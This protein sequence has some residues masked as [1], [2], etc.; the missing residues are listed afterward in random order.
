MTP[1]QKI[2]DFKEK[3][4]KRITE[5]IKEVTKEAG[6]RT[7]KFVILRTLS[8][9]GT[10]GQL[11]PLSGS[12]KEFRKRWS[13]FLD[14]ST[15]PNKSNLTATGQ[16][17]RALYLRVVKD[18]FFIKV[19]SK[20]RD[21]SLGGSNVK[22]IKRTNKK[23]GATKSIGYE[24]DLTNDQVREYTEKGGRE[25]LKL[26]DAETNTLRRYVTEKFKERLKDLL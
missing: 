9:S 20:K 7:L 10:S 6:E 5:T 22:E 8:G 4:A 18:R 21:E 24:S 12:Y 17:L 3:Y 13:A 14:Q 23:T 26:S 25:F 19:N 2:K 1:E 16:L 15:S 11:K